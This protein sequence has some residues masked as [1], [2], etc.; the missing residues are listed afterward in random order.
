ML[1]INKK[2]ESLSRI[3][4][5]SAVNENSM[6]NL[7]YDEYINAV[8]NLMKTTGQ[9]EVYPAPKSKSSPITVS[10]NSDKIGKKI[11]ETV[12]E[13]NK[14]FFTKWLTK[15]AIK[16]INAGARIGKNGRSLFGMDETNGWSFIYKSDTVKGKNGDS[17]SAADMEVV[18]A[19]AYNNK[20]SK[21]KK[22]VEANISY[23]A[24]KTGKDLE[25]IIEPT[26]V[27]YENNKTWLDGVADSIY[28]YF[29][30]SHKIKALRKLPDSAV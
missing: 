25:K 26:R 20:Y 19:F 4:E 28:N 30:K 11:P 5:R 27:Y 13:F 6:T 3:F 23:S 2:Y 18:I 10:V 1:F 14:L 21:Y 9:V 12:E 7:K 22:D 24:Q 15:D 8:M 29:S 17:V 16:Q